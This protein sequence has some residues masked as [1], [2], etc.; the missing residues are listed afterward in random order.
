VRCS[1][2]DESTRFTLLPSDQSGIAFENTLEFQADFN[3][4]TYP[5]F[6][7]GGGVALGD[8]NGDHLPDIFLTGNQVSNRLY[9]NKGGLKFEDAT[10]QAGIASEGWSTG[11]TMADVNGDGWLDIYV[12]QVHYETQAGRNHL[13]INNQDG[14]FTEEAQRYGLDFVGLSTQAAFLDYDRDGDLDLYILNHSVHSTQSFGPA[15]RRTIDAP[16]A[17]DRLYRNEGGK[18]FVNVTANAGIFSSALGYGLGLAVSDINDDGWPDIYVGNDFHENDYLYLNRGDGTFDEVLQHITGHTSQSTMGVDIADIDNDVW[19]DIVALDMMPSDWETYQASGG[20]DAEDIA[21][22]K[23][24]FGYAPQVARNT[25]QLHRGLDSLGLPFFSEIG[26]FLGI[27]ATDWSWT[28]LLADLDGDGWKDLFVTNGIPH[29]PNDL[30]YIAYVG[31]PNVQR[32]LAEN[33]APGMQAA[34]NRMPEVI[35][36]NYTFKN[37][38]GNAFVDVSETWGLGHVGISNGAA[39]GDLDGDG[40]LDLV[41]NNINAPVS[42]YRNNSADHHYLTV[43][44][45][46]AGANTTGI[47]ARVI[48]HANNQIQVQEQAPTRGFQSSVPHILVFGLGGTSSVETL[49]VRWPDGAVQTLH[50]VAAD[51][52][53][54]LRQQDADSAQQPLP[55]DPSSPL[56]RESAP[57]AWQHQENHFEDFAYEPLIPHRLSTQGPALAVADV[58]GDNLNDAFLGGAAG[59]ASILLM[60]GTQ[61]LPQQAFEND[62]AAEDV[63]ATFL[64]AD[65]D[66]DPDLYVVRGGGESD[67]TLWTDRLYMNDGTGTF[68]P[69]TQN[70]PHFLSNGCCV[71]AADH[72]GDGDT[73]LFVGSRA[74][75]GA[76]GVSPRSYLL[77]NDGTGKFTDVTPPVL[78]EIGM[79]TDAAWANVTGN[80]ALDLVLVGEW[81]PITVLENNAGMLTDVTDALGLSQT[82]G[83]WQS[84]LPGD[85]DGDGDIDL[86]AGNLGLNS[87]LQAPMDLYVHDF[88]NDGRSDPLIAWGQTGDIWPRRDALAYQLR[89][90][91]TSISSYAAYAH[92]NIHTLADTESVERFRVHS[93]ASVYLENRDHFVVHNLPDEAQWSPIMNMVSKDFNGDGALDIL[94]VGN[95]HGAS[96][97]QGPYDASYGTLLLGNRDSTFTIARET[98]LIV[99]GEARH[100]RSLSPESLIIARNN[101]PPQILRTNGQ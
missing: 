52:R 53:L 69:A 46:G 71:S 93:F 16:Y 14:T 33:S 68:S 39:Y 90:I 38:R 44:L 84:V 8:I 45:E 34:I 54:T 79:I 62:A 2:P 3:I 85:Y 82:G 50:D 76:Y 11:A 21:H 94:A 74:V 67:T 42:V 92:T 29:R 72:D 15:W 83:W 48:I 101:Q 31:Q 30:D 57:V 5:Y 88:D 66:G 25:L 1:T 77:R 27:H 73:D 41:I 49:V 22:I 78:L 86:V 26:A 56:F 24:N 19:P 63:A 95:F 10:K 55:A 99:R 91:V 17:G 51:Q 12:C 7:D 9:V 4:I 37:H 35:I 80:D 98:G 23:R 59:Q 89:G 40:D 60:Q 32:L 70:L 65:G 18:H 100:V 81:M 87:V 96:A 13:Y 43:S 20:P 36:P 58:N 47:G 6:Y 64:D 28:P 61:P 97:A 75:P